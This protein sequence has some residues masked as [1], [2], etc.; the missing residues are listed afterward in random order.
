MGKTR[1]QFMLRTFFACSI[2]IFL[3]ACGTPAADKRVEITISAA[4]SLSDSMQEV[5]TLFERSHKDVKLSFNFAASGTLQRQIEQGAPADLFFSAGN[6]QMEALIKQQLIEPKYHTT[7]LTNRLVLIVPS[8]AHLNIQALSDL[9]HADISKIAVGQPESVPAGKYTQEALTSSGLWDK[10]NPKLVFRKDVRQ[11]LSYVETGNVDAGFVYESDA[12]SSNKVKIAL[13]VDPSSHS[14]IEYPVGVLKSAKHK[15]EA[16]SVYSF[17]LSGE[18]KDIF[19][20]YGFSQ[21][22]ES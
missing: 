21:A 16:E 13:S 5:K 12:K 6:N 1:I 8:A 18:A 14:R 15:Q 9:L 3:G 7:A 20:K 11:V 17:L 4:A 2:L 19:V 22:K 10:L